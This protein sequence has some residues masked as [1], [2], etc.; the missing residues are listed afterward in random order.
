MRPAS[1]SIG[2]NGNTQWIPIDY[3]QNAFGLSVAVTLSSTGN[4][5]WTVQHTFDDFSQDSTRPITI[6][7]SG[8]TAT[9]TDTG[10]G[11]NTNDNVIIAGSGS[12]NLDTANA[13]ITV[14][15]DNTYTYTVGN[16]GATA[17]T[18]QALVKSFRVFNSDSSGL[19]AQTTRKDGSYSSPITGVRL[20]VA[21]YTAGKATLS[22][23]QG[24]GR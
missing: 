14:T 21:S 23:L 19:V 11:L 18:G 24:Q 22:V 1:I 6:A 20:K 3:T 17:D 16:T 10:H 7:R 15:D 9:V 5:T 4:L 2:A 12:S 13:T 8:T